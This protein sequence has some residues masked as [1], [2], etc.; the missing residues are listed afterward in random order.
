MAITRAQLMADTRQYMDAVDSSRWSDALVRTV[1]NQVF[2]SEWSNILNAAP[3]YTFATRNVTTDSNGQV[4]FSSFDGGSGDSEQNFYRVLA[5]TDGNYIY[6]QTRFQDV[7]LS[8][9]SNYPS[10]YPK[11]YYLVGTYLQTVPN[12][13]N[14]GLYV[15]VNYKP[16]SLSDLA[17]DASVIEFPKD[18]HLLLAYEGAAQLLLKGGAESSAAAVLKQM[19]GQERE[20]LLDD[21]RRRTI[22]PT[23]LAYPDT[24]WEW[25]GA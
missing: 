20:T 9:T 13:T 19:A 3:Y 25:A 2:D 23:R 18:A 8:T 24:P 15:Y 6:Q 22:N 16:T 7:P 21:L 12:Q 11:L 10:S 14:T 5:V 17:S 4:Q 1:L